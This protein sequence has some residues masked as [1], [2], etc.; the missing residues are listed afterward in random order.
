MDHTHS[1]SIDGQS[2]V[3]TTHLVL[4]A[5]MGREEILATKAEVRRLLDARTFEHVTIDVALEGE[6]SET[7]SHRGAGTAGEGALGAEAPQ[8]HHHH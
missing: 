7:D 8:G 4:R 2:H 5:G 1:W 3:L 6:E